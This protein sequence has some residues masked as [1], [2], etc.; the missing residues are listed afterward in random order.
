MIKHKNPN[1]PVQKGLGIWLEWVHHKA[2]VTSY[3]ET[4]QHFINYLSNILIH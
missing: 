2:L 1:T 4:S 3:F